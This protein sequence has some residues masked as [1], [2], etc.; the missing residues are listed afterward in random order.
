M[1][2][3]RK[4]AR[5][6]PGNYLGLRS[7]FVTICSD[8]RKP[9]L[10]EP[11]V[12]TRVLALLQACAARASFLL[13][14]YCLMPDHLHFLAQ[15]S[16]PTSDLREFV[17]V[18]KQRTSFEFRQ[19]RGIPLWEMSYHDHIVRS[20]DAIEDVACYIWWNPVRKHLCSSPKEFAFSGSQTI[21]WMQRSAMIPSWSA[22]GKRTPPI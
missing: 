12:A 8:M 20:P 11:P 15:G 6:S 9:Y 2:I 22:P 14:A 19:L 1:T 5:L 4:T 17:R 7:H 18:F 13:H 16:E 3:H 21:N 10:A